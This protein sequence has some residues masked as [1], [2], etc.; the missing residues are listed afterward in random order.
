MTKRAVLEESTAAGVRV[1]IFGDGLASNQDPP[2]GAN[3]RPGMAVKVVF[4]R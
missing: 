4:K 3:L 1:E 2:A